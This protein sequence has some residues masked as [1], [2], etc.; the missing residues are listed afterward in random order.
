MMNLAVL[1]VGSPR[2]TTHETAVQLLHLL[3]SRFF[4]EGPV[5]TDNPDELQDLS[6]PL[7]D[8]L[9][10]VAY[11]HSQMD[12]TTQLARLHPDLTMPMSFYISP[13]LLYPSSPHPTKGLTS[14]FEEH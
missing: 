3:D 6:R 8:I 13:T 5:F 7:N 12:L 11:C 9:L 10:A 4:E 1:N 14:N 2:I